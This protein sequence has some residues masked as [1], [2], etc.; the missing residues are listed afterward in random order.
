MT[1]HIISV[2]QH[3][4]QLPLISMTCLDSTINTSLRMLYIRH[5]WI[6]VNEWHHVLVLALN[7]H[8]HLQVWWCSILWNQS[9]RTPTE[10]P[11]QWRLEVH[12]TA[13]DDSCILVHEGETSSSNR[14][15]S[16]SNVYITDEPNQC[17]D[18][19]EYHCVSLIPWRSREVSYTYLEMQWSLCLEITLLWNCT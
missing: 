5:L 16:W 18:W 9:I 17:R 4:M 10:V 6:G 2:M 3:H 8:R 1:T 14:S 12:I 11:E 19:T 15:W 13:W 7:R